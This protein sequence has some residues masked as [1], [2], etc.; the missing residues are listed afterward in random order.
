M[1]SF[2]HGWQ[3][4]AGYVT[5]VMA[6]LCIGG[7]IRSLVVSDVVGIGSNAFGSTRGG[8]WWFKTNDLDLWE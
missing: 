4:R 5:L 2:F 6:N 1:H 3:R 8:I 7:W